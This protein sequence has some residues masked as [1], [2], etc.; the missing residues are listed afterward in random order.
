MIVKN[1]SE[2]K[3]QLSALVKEVQEGREVLIAKSGTPVAK[4]IAYHGAKAPR[5]PG[6]LGGKIVIQPD[7]DEL[8]GDLQVAFGVP[9][10]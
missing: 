7:F 6:V 8:P 5:E 3:A 2:A 1:I 10:K 4:L 9:D